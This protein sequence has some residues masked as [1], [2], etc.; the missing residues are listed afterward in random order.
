MQDRNKPVVPHMHQHSVGTH[1][2]KNGMRGG[3]GGA[4]GGGG[5]GGG[6]S[7]GRGNKSTKPSDAD[8]IKDKIRKDAAAH[9]LPGNVSADATTGVT[10]T[11]F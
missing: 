10:V 11:R 9:L 3:G 7:S 2:S 4:G 8:Q 5:G 6:G 1:K